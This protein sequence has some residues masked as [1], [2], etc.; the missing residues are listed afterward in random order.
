[1]GT[2]YLSHLSKHSN[3]HSSIVQTTATRRISRL[4]HTFLW[5]NASRNRGKVNR[6]ATKAVTVIRHDVVPLDTGHKSEVAPLG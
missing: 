4:P 3:C 6:L 5:Y 2:S 1:M